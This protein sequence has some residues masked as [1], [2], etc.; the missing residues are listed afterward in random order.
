MNNLTGKIFERLT[1]IKPVGSSKT[2]RILWLCKCECGN[3]I[4]AES[5]SLVMGNKK[6]C[7]CLQTERRKEANTDHGYC[8]TRIHRIWKGMKARCNIKSST[9]FKWYGEKGVKVCDE[10]DQFPKF[11]QWAMGNGYSEELT[12]DRIDPCGNYSPENCR[13]V[14]VAEQNMNKRKDKEK[15]R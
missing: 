8:G 5:T 13:W 7:G 9:D 14:T 1:A 2:K 15:C 11:L 10:W 12:L 4:T 3:E 6:S